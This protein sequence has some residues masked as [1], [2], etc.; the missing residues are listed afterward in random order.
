VIKKKEN[1][2]ID[3]K[4]LIILSSSER[5]FAFQGAR[6]PRIIALM[7]KVFFVLFCEMFVGKGIL[8]TPIKSCF[9]S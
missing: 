5:N 6:T 1:K 2:I 3:K 4:R 9:G 7:E 8:L